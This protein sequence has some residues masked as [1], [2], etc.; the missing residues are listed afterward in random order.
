MC[1]FNKADNQDAD[2]SQCSDRS[3]CLASIG[4]K[5]YADEVQSRT[6]YESRQVAT[7]IPEH[8]WW[9]DRVHSQIQSICH[10]PPNVSVSKPKSLVCPDE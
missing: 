5:W 3:V 6:K 10:L 8:S 9:T 2:M 1:L 4:E 7:F